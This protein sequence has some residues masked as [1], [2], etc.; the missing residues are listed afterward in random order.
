MVE[1]HHTPEQVRSLVILTA[2]HGLIPVL[3]NI[4]V[5]SQES[6]VLVMVGKF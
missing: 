2:Q 4:Q 3:V 6:N 1:F 5:T